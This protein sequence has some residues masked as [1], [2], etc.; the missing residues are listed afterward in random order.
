[1]ALIKFMPRPQKRRANNGG[2]RQHIIQNSKQNKSSVS[3]GKGIAQKFLKST[4]YNK[5]MNY[6]EITMNLYP[7]KLNQIP[8]I[9]DE[10]VRCVVVDAPDVKRICFETGYGK[11]KKAIDIR[12]R[13]SH[14]LSNTL[15]YAPDKGGGPKTFKFLSDHSNRI[16]IFPQRYDDYAQEQ[17]EKEAQSQEMVDAK[18]AKKQRK[19]NKKM[20]KH[21]VANK[22]RKN[23]KYPEPKK[24]KKT[25]AIYDRKGEAL[26]SQFVTPG[27]ED[28]DPIGES[29][30]TDQ[31]EGDRDDGSSADEIEETEDTFLRNFSNLQVMLQESREKGEGRADVDI[32]KGVK[33]GD[34][35][36]YLAPDHQRYQKKPQLIE[37]NKK[38]LERQRRNK[39]NEIRSRVDVVEDWQCEFCSFCNRKEDAMCQMCYMEC[40]RVRYNK[41]MNVVDANNEMNHAQTINGVRNAEND[42]KP[43]WECEVCTFI[44]TGDNELCDMCGT[45]N[46]EM[47]AKMDHKYDNYGHGFFADS[48][49]KKVPYKTHQ[50][51]SGNEE[52]NVWDVALD[53]E[54][55][56]VEEDYTVNEHIANI[57]R[58]RQANVWKEYNEKQKRINKQQRLKRIPRNDI[59]FVPHQKKKQKNGGFVAHKAA[60]AND[61]NHIECA[62]P[63]NRR[64]RKNRNKKRKQMV[65]KNERQINTETM[66]SAQS[67]AIKFEWIDK[68]VN[69]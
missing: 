42:G 6:T 67:K 66:A 50:K 15:G 28:N 1:M 3:R 5:K 49:P 21:F 56:E 58:N 26:P 64:K 47:E 23:L 63:S 8:G 10:I 44:N 59:G 17:A 9:L 14:Y 22:W 16:V 54:E 48:A 24:K 37:N 65:K 38:E 68:L 41:F 53:I 62:P 61:V 39:M 34:K 57:N 35:F 13:C 40:L 12:K 4:I 27:G 45:L 20:K 11:P 30:D 2:D 7:H 33:N 19:A 52:M 29:D 31:E 51:Q 69:M 18:N 60:I 36:E 55:E 25:V 32:F 46:Q 43:K